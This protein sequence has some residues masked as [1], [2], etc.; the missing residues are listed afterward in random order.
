MF[1]QLFRPALKAG[2]FSNQLQQVFEFEADALLKLDIP[3]FYVPTDSDALSI[4]PGNGIPK[5]LWESPLKTVERRINHMSETALQHHREV[6]RQSLGRKPKILTSPLT[7][8]EMQSLV[9][10]YADLT[11]AMAGPAVKS[12]LWTLPSFVEVEPPLIERLGLYSGDLGT[13]IFLAAA[14]RFLHRS[15]VEPLLE[16]FRDKLEKFQVRSEPLGIGN[17]VGSLIY[18]TLL[19]G[20]ILEDQSWYNLSERLFCQLTEEQVRIELEPDLLYGIAGLLVAV[21]R[22]YHLRPDDQKAKLA[23]VCLEKLVESFHPDEGWKRPNGDS[24]LGF[25]HG[26][27]GISYAAA[28][29]GDI[30]RDNRAQLLAEKGL[31]FDR[32]YFREAEHNWPS[33]INDPPPASMRAWCSGLIGMLV[34][35]IGI[36]RS[37]RDPAV[38]AEIETNLPFLPDLLGLDHWCCGSAGVA[39]AL[40]YAAQVFDR[41]ELLEKARTT[42]DQAVRR[43]LKT[44]YYRFSPHVGQNYCFQP[45]LFRGLAGLGFS[46]IR[47]S[48]PASLPS[49][50]AFEIDP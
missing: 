38:L 45:S 10:E 26:A 39:E 33:T 44:T 50:T 32:R 49:I 34:S 3:R 37:W 43:A 7:R 14:D 47:I 4:D 18:G 19:L 42:I 2:Y 8:G 27:A 6:I 36:W 35:R 1:E 31:E 20:S 25:A 48:E 30:F 21:G 9:Q 13:L 28:I 23:G 41:K 29:A 11:L 12:T 16:H 24:A 17:G 40:I 5:F 46:L 15:T 22:L